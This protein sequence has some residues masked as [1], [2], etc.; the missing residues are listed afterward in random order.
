[1]STYTNLPPATQNNSFGKQTFIN[2]YTAPLEISATTLDAITAFFTSRNFDSV[3]ASSLATTLIAQAKKDQVNPLTMLDTLRGYDVV[4]LNSL[5]AE[6]INY[7][8]YKT[9]Y[10]GFGPIFA[11]NPEVTRNILP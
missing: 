5:M 4:Q 9:S 11:P 6:V 3:S 2:F 1:M 7:N 8:R 10:L